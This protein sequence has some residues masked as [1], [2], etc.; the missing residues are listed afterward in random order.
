MC[1]PATN[2]ARCMMADGYAR[3]T[4]NVGVV[5]VTS[6]PG[7]T[8]T[9][10]GIATAY[11]DCRSASWS[12]P[13]RCRAA[14]SAPTAFQESDI[15]GITMPVVKHSFLLQSTDDLT[16]HLPRGV[17]HRLDRS[18]RPGA[19]RHPFRHFRSREDGLPTIPIR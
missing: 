12:S 7:A 5:I 8:N 14:S 11:M 16:T 19:H 1:S 15:V 13:A 9:V 6:G 18:S 2:R 4:G 10:T 3:A 17:L